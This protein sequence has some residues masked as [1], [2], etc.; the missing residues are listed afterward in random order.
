MQL[1]LNFDVFDGAWAF[2]EFY[3]T[4]CGTDISD[5]FLEIRTKSL[6]CNTAFFSRNYSEQDNLAGETAAP[7]HCT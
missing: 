5:T 7:I 1:I 2:A 3:M 6:F 4:H